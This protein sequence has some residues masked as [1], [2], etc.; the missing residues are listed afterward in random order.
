LTVSV[1]KWPEFLITDPEVWVR[2]SA[3]PDF[4]RRNGSATGPLIFMSTV[5]ELLGRNISGSGLESRGYGSRDPL[6]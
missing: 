3:I 6:R 1:V 2:F 4:L 5:E